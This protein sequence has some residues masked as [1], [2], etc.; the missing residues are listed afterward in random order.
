MALNTLLKALAGSLFLSTT[1]LASDVSN[2][3]QNVVPNTM[4]HESVDPAQVQHYKSLLDELSQAPTSTPATQVDPSVL[5]NY[6]KWT[7]VVDVS[8]SANTCPT[9]CYACAAG[10]NPACCAGRNITQPESTPPTSSNPDPDTNSP[11]LGGS[12]PHP[13]ACPCYCA[14]GCPANIQAIC[15]VTGGARKDADTQQPLG[16][17]GSEKFHP[18]GL[19]LPETC[20]CYCA[21]DCPPN[22]QAICC[23]TGGA[24]VVEKEGPTNGLVMQ[25]ASGDPVSV[26][27]AVNLTVEQ[28]FITLDLVRGLER[29][30]EIEYV[31]K[32]GAEGHFEIVLDVVAGEKTVKQAFQVING[33]KLWEREQILLGLLFVARIDALSVKEDVLKEVAGLPILTGTRAE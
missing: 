19:P 31:K 21:P 1:V 6:F 20:P 17:T 33:S 14:P 28:S 11:S 18:R 15:C 13:L 9:S 29:T 22:I 27:A 16:E 3:S 7:D 12:R 10:C 5:D 30:S 32:D 26:L 8:D 23:V 2:S 25:T 24:K 4:D